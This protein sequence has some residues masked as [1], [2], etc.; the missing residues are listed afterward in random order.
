MILECRMMWRRCAKIIKNRGFINL[1]QS[2]GGVP[3]VTDD[4]MSHPAM[5][6]Q[7]DVVFNKMCSIYAASFSDFI[8]LHLCPFVYAALTGSLQVDRQTTGRRPPNRWSVDM[9]NF[10][11]DIHPI[12]PRP[13]K[14]WVWLKIIGNKKVPLLIHWL[15]IIL[16]RCCTLL[17]FL[18]DLIWR[19]SEIGVCPDHA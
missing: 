9:S 19:F 1:N 7:H 15:H 18:F 11:G 2:H 4:F 17:K 6:L 16:R 3:L 10:R 14:I 8:W 5:A 12:S 13:G